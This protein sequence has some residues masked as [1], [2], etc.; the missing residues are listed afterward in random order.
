M[1][2]Y[3]Q[4]ATPASTAESNV[5]SGLVGGRHITKAGLKILRVKRSRELTCFSNG[6]VPRA[7]GLV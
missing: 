4:A 5:S 3:S 6:K 1:K 2:G 7:G